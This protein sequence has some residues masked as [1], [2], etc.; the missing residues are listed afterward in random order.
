MLAAFSVAVTALV[1]IVAG[2]LS[3]P[4]LAWGAGA[5]AL[6]AVM[7]MVD[8]QAGRSIAAI[9]ATGTALVIACLV[10]QLAEVQDRFFDT[11]ASAAGAI[12]L[13]WTVGSLFLAFALWRGP[14]AGPAL[15]IAAALVA[16]SAAGAGYAWWKDRPPFAAGAVRA[17]ATVRFTDE[18]TV[19]RDARALGV[20]GLTGLVDIPTRQQFIGRV[21]YSAPPCGGCT[22]HVIVID[23]RE[24]EVA[25][26][27]YSADG[28]G[29]SSQ[30]GTLAARYPWLS[31]TAPTITDAGYTDAGSSVSRAADEPGPIAFA[32]SFT[33]AARVPDFLVALVLSGP[34]SQIFW[35][36]RVSG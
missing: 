24:N 4:V 32:G 20:T 28:G 7:A 30:L 17:T 16:V 33:G 15:L 13:L 36:K 18:T 11:A 10:R 25:D 26:H 8:R 31:A 2:G 1:L 6:A 19:D 34:E 21:D 14:T 22:Y 23:K 29:W 5:L 27:L 9:T 35:A 12:V 3:G